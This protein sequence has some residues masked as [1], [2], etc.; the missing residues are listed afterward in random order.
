VKVA[1]KIDTEADMLKKTGIIFIIATILMLLHI[2]CLAGAR[3]TQTT[4]TPAPAPTT[5][6]TETGPTLGTSPGTVAPKFK[7]SLVVDGNISYMPTVNGMVT[8]GANMTLGFYIKNAGLAES[9]DLGKYSIQCTVLSGGEC[10]VANVSNKSVPNLAPSASKSYTLMQTKA[11]EKGKY[12]VI[13]STQPTSAR[14]RPRQIEFTVGDTVLKKTKKP[15]ATR[16]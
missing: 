16:Q 1:T 2:T 14:G 15:R 9:G 5:S 8:P 10:P 6:P 4:Q 13:I 11:A 3:S 7:P 12:R